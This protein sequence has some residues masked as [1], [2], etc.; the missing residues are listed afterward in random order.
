MGKNPTFPLIKEHIDM[1]HSRMTALL[2]AG[3]LA[4]G[5]LTACGK[6]DIIGFLVL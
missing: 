6:E 2:L 1:N 5:S 4:V 3:V